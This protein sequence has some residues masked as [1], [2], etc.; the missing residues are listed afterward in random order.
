MEKVSCIICAYNE[1]ERIG[2][3]LAAVTD[4]PDLDEVIVVNGGSTDRTAEVVR[5]YKNAHLITCE[6]RG[7]SYA[8]TVGLSNAKNPIIILLDADLKG[9]TAESVTALIAPVTSG[10]ADMSISLRKNSLP[11]YRF[12]GLD[13]VSGER[14]FRKALLS[15]RLP[16]IAKLPGFGFE[17][18]MNRLIINQ[19]LRLRVVDLK[20]VISPRK[21]AKIGWWK[22]RVA[23]LDMIRE[24]L[25]VI[26]LREVLYQNYKMLKLSRT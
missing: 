15:E 2:G 24:I 5:A 13:F 4:H 10:N 3:V 21:S 1:A 23:D 8:I 17:V 14:V 11:A 16:E 18:Y 25:K 6:N 19:K 20:N 9:L 22:G 7:K 26:P 12:I